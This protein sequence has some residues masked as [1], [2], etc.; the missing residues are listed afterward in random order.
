[1]G[2]FVE[3]VT[4]MT[5]PPSGPILRKVAPLL[6]ITDRTTGQALL[7]RNNHELKATALMLLETGANISLKPKSNSSDGKRITTATLFDDQLSHLEKY[8]Q[9]WL[10]MVTWLSKQTNP[11]Y[12]SVCKGLLYVIQQVKIAE[13]TIGEYDDAAIDMLRLYISATYTEDNFMIDAWTIDASKGL[14]KWT[15]WWI[16]RQNT[17]SPLAVRYTQHC[18]TRTTHVMPL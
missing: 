7:A 12:S 14:E 5:H 8:A 3:N 1:M 16:E 9:S 18:Q 6:I 10:G 15:I 2:S 11:R 4:M 17:P 13:P